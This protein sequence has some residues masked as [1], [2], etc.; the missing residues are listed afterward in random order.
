M[1]VET[2]AQKAKLK[3]VVYAYDVASPVLYS[4]A[5][6]AH[7]LCHV[8]NIHFLQATVHLENAR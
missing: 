4:R 3:P 5:I 1:L 2:P 7:I 8:R 6:K